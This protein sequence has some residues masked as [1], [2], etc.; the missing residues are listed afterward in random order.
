MPPLRG[1]GVSVTLLLQICRPDGTLIRFFSHDPTNELVAIHHS[2]S[3]VPMGL[4]LSKIFGAPLRQSSFP[5]S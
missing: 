1:S 2:E 5:S 4:G 3:A